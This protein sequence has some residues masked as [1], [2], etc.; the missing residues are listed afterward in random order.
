MTYTKYSTIFTDPHRYSKTIA[1]ARKCVELCWLM[2]VQDP[3]LAFGPLPQH[4]D[5]YNADMYR[6]YTR[7]GTLVDFIV[8]PVLQLYENGPVL[9]KGVVEPIKD[10]WNDNRTET[11]SY[12]TIDRD[13]YFDTDYRRHDR[14]L[15]VDES[16]RPISDIGTYSTQQEVDSIFNAERHRVGGHSRRYTDRDYPTTS[17]VRHTSSFGYQLTTSSVSGNRRTPQKY[18][19]SAS[20]PYSAALHE[21]GWRY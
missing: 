15:D 3:P 13:H 14:D 18:G 1:F 2:A 17:G 20:R 7:S 8:W 10:G 12:G 16:S 21:K 11:R 6:E 4:L 9:S 19:S 5:R